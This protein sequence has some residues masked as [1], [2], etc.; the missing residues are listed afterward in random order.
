MDKVSIQQIAAVLTQKRGLTVQEAETFTTTIFDIVRETLPKESQVKIKGLGTFKLVGVEARESVN[1][2]SGERFMIDG[3][4][5]I[6]F[7]PDTDMKEMVN[8]PF[9][10]FETVVLDEDSDLERQLEEINATEEERQEEE[11]RQEDEEKP[12]K[13]EKPEEEE[14]PVKEERLAGSEP[15]S[16]A[17]LPV[18]SAVAELPEEKLPEEK[19]QES[20]EEELPEEK[21]QESPEEELPEEKVLES[22][23]EETSDSLDYKEDSEVSPVS[24]HRRY[25]WMLWSVL[26]LIIAA[27]A[28]CLGYWQ[29]QQT[30]PSPASET[31]PAPAIATTVPEGSPEGIP[32][33][34]TAAI[35]KKD[36]T[37][38]SADSVTI[39][40]DTTAA[41]TKNDATAAPPKQQPAI[42]EV[43]YKK[44]EQMDVRV[45]TGAYRII[46]TDRVVTARRGD[47]LSRVSRRELGDGMV[48]YVA[49]YNG[50]T[51]DQ[52]LT[53]GQKI[54]IPKLKWKTKARK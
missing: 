32:A 49:V 15:E 17:P 51:D 10:Q 13:E 48:C 19:V 44:Y 23:E 8:K 53:E 16:P 34:T 14:K 1:I 4:E 43:D 41:T 27:G 35:T 24:P 11:I 21:V 2:R 47:N 25:N 18:V 31:T 28:Y 30:V 36:S 46:G 50:M 7:T 5:K 40:L 42:D 12:E 54:K 29:G 20:P 33:D 37:T 9:S 26:S 38:T 52:P 45:R 22:P 6:T 39:A 3:H